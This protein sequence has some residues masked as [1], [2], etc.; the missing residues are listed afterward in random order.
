MWS[1]TNLSR[2]SWTRQNELFPNQ[3]CPEHTEIPPY[4]GEK[5]NNQLEVFRTPIYTHVTVQEVHAL[6]TLQLESL[7]QNI[8]VKLNCLAVLSTLQLG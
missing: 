3:E 5:N 8:P 6:H 2:F 7:I 4:H 1:L